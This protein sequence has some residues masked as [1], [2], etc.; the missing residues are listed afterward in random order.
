MDVQAV[1]KPPVATPSGPVPGQPGGGG[2]ES[3][4]AQAAQAKGAE[5]TVK[6]RADA[7]AM[8]LEQGK[9]DQDQLKK[10]LEKL[11]IFLNALE[12]QMKFSV[13]EG[14]G[15]VIV[16]VVNTETGKVIREIPPQRILDM[17]A[18]MME[19]VGVLLDERA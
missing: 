2:V 11:N 13:H 7:L 17:V 1:M 10:V 4:K 14:T 8:A 9:I 19:M 5:Q 12:V 6:A 3:A 16:R 18:K 15:Q